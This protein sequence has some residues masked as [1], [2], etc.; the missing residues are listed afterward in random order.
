MTAGLEEPTD[1]D[2]AIPYYWKSLDWAALTRDYPPPPSFGKTTGRLSA[3]ALR[4]L[5]N[6]RFL[7]RMQDA[8]KIT[9]QWHQQ[10]LQQ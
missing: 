8:W 4:K 1:A 6:M 10:G 9:E 3:D 5:Q 2:D 7:E